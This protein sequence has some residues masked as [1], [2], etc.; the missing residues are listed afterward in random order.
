MPLPSLRIASD[1]TVKTI[2]TVKAHVDSKRKIQSM[3]YSMYQSIVFHIISLLE[4]LGRL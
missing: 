2:K 3:L 1:M 4:K